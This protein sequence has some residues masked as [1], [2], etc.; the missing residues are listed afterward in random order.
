MFADTIRISKQVRLLELQAIVDAKESIQISQEAIDQTLPVISP[1][2]REKF[3]EFLAA[4]SPE[5]KLQPTFIENA[6][7]MDKDQRTNFHQTIKANF[8]FL[9]SETKETDDLKTI[10][11]RYSPKQKGR[12]VSFVLRKRNWDTMQAL[13]K[14]ARF[15]KKRPG[16]FFFAG[17]KDRRGETVQNVVVKGLL[18][19]Q[20]A[21][22]IKNDK[23]N[24]EEISFSKLGYTENLIKI[25][26]LVGNRFSIAF[27]FV[28]DDI[29]TDSLLKNIE[30][31]SK[32]G[33]INYFGLQRFGSKAEV[34]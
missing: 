8:P 26:D 17:T 4:L 1:E 5:N 31:V 21:G 20:L 6:T 18:T 19:K 3:T 29:H 27:R 15:L 9:S 23:W 11:V 22:L 34:T 33:F 10:I 12:L 32:D 24:W 28:D 7:Y 14:I 13:N 2:N 25:G 16:D 30:T